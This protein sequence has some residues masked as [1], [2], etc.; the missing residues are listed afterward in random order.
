MIMVM[1]MIMIL[2]GDLGLVVAGDEA[3]EGIISIQ[4]IRVVVV[5]SLRR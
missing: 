4:G 1:M 3:E 5:S 2:R